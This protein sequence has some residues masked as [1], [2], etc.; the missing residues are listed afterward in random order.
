MPYYDIQC[1]T[2]GSVDTVF[3]KIAEY[4][5]LPE[6]CG[7]K[8]SR[9]VCAPNVIA[10]IQPYRSM[11]DGRMIESRVEHRKHLKE[12]G[13]TEVGTDTMER[14]TDHFAQKKRGDEIRK[15]ISQRLEAIS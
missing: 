8:M 2:C 3:R 14:K 11:I 7:A 6:C 4:D 5:D 1:K 9:K 12:H 15:E 13:C 10:D